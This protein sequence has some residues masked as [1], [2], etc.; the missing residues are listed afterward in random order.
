MDR[1]ALDAA[2]AAGLEYGGWC[3][4]G[5]WAEDR[6]HP[7]G[8]LAA[9]PRLTETPG[10][11]PDQ[12]T[13]WNV[14]DSDATLILTRAGARSPGTELTIA[15]AAEMGRPF[16][17][18]DLEDPAAAGAIDALVAGLEGDAT[19]N[20]AGPRESE[21]PGILAGARELL[22]GWLAAQVDRRSGGTS[23]T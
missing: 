6:T 2:I 10:A 8:V 14:R 3:P 1:A 11:D 13:R 21:A 12:R 17:V 23:A 4:H 9:Y 19:L 7:P 5:G 18:V 16:A 20:V 22:D 15:V